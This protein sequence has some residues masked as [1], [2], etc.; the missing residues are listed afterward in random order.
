MTTEQ[1]KKGI[2]LVNSIEDYRKR[3]RQISSEYSEARGIHINDTL[4]LNE[5]LRHDLFNVLIAHCQQK[6][7]ELEVELENL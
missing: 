4:W 7:N 3:L 6:I 1:A 2:D 5:K